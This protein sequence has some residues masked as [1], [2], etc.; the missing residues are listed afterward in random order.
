MYTDNDGESSHF[1]GGE[2]IQVKQLAALGRD[3]RFIA[4]FANVPGSAPGLHGTAFIAGGSRGK[5][6]REVPTITTAD[7]NMRSYT[8][9]THSSNETTSGTHL[10][11]LPEPEDEDNAI[12]DALRHRGIRFCHARRAKYLHYERSA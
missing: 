4:A 12:T 6:S 11:P 5:L 1:A 2:D 8:R 3:R 7:D 10:P 9:G